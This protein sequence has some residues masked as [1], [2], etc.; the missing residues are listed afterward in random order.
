M[1]PR[2]RQMSFN[3]NPHPSRINFN[4]SLVHASY[5]SRAVA[6]MNG[7]DINFHGTGRGLTV[8]NFVYCVHAPAAENLRGNLHL[9]VDNI[10]LL[11]RE[12]TM[13]WYLRFRVRAHNLC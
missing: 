9:V 10:C 7:W 4:A 3:S 8:E 12:R 1:A 13:E 6:S 5:T 2:N 11:L